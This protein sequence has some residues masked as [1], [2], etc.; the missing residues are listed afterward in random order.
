ML[1]AKDASPLR[2]DRGE[3]R[4]HAVAAWVKSIRRLG[5]LALSAPK[6]DENPSVSASDVENRLGLKQSA[7]EQMPFRISL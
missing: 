7:K 5:R 6:S 4:A 3:V 2:R 1:D